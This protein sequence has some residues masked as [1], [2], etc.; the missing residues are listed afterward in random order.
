MIG[1]GVDL[2]QGI[3]FHMISAHEGLPLPMAAFADGCCDQGEQKPALR[4]SAG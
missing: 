2:I 4:V 3:I 1:E